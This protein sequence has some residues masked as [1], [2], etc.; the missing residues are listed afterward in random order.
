MIVCIEIFDQIFDIFRKL[1]TFEL[2]KKKVSITRET[3]TLLV[4]SP[5]TKLLTL[6]P[7]IIT[8]F[9]LHPSSLQ[10]SYFHS[11]SFENTVKWNYYLVPSINLPR[12][13]HGLFVYLYTTF[14]CCSSSSSCS[15]SWR[16]GGERL[17]AH[18]YT[19]GQKYRVG[20]PNWKAHRTVTRTTLGTVPRVQ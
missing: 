10:L 4:T 2:K 20:M 3:Q 15:S 13:I 8:V 5:K 1:S 17:V 9:M 14:S 18:I 19:R 11:L 12:W 7:T 16:K 6:F